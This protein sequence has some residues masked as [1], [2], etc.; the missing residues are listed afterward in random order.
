[1][2]CFTSTLVASLLVTGVVATAL[3]QNNGRLSIEDGVVVKFGANSGMVVHRELETYGVVNFTS[4]GDDTLAGQTQQQ[5]GMPARGDWLGIR[6]TPEVLPLRCKFER[7]NIRYAGQNGA[8]GLDVQSNQVLEGVKISQSDVGLAIS[9]GAV[10]SVREFSLINNR[11][12]LQSSNAIPKIRDSVLSLNLDF[13]ASN[14][15]TSVPGSVP[16]DAKQNYWGAASGPFDAF[17]NPNGTGDK[18]T[19][20]IDYGSYLAHAPLIG[21]TIKP[22]DG[23]YATNIR[24][25]QMLTDCEGA[26]E[27]R[28]S[29]SRLY[30]GSI[31][32]PL[33]SSRA[34]TLSA[35]EGEK[36]IYAQFR[37]A[38]GQTRE[39]F[40]RMHLQNSGALVNITSPPQGSIFTTTDLVTIEAQVE[41]I[42]T[43]IISAV[44]FYINGGL[45]GTDNN[46][47]YLATWNPTGY[48]SGN[49][50]IKAVA[51]TSL[52][53][54][55]FNRINVVL[56][57]PNGPADTA[58][59]VINNIRFNTTPLIEG[60]AITNVGYLTATVSDTGCANN[61][62]VRLTVLLN[63]IPAGSDPS[64][65]GNYRHYLG[66]DKILNGP[67]RLRLAAQDNAGN[68]T[69]V[70]RN[71]ILALGPPAVPVITAP[72]QNQIVRVNPI[73][74][75]GTSDPGT[76]VQLYINNV[77][78]GLPRFASEAGTFENDY[79]LLPSEGTLQLSADATNGQ[80]TSARSANRTIQFIIPPASI[81]VSSPSAGFLVVGP[82]TLGAS[83]IN[84]R[85]GTT[86]E[87]FVN[88][89]SFGVDTTEP[90]SMPFSGVGQSDGVKTVRVLM[91]DTSSNTSV[92]TSAFIYRAAAAIAPEFLP[93]YIGT[94]LSALP[95]VSS[96]NVPIV[97]AGRIR[98]TATPTGQGNSAVTLVLRTQGFERRIN[99]VSEANGDFNYSYTPRTTDEGVFEVFA[100]HPQAK[101]FI[102]PTPTGIA[103]FT[104]QRLSASPARIALQAPRAFGQPFAITVRNSA[105]AIA[106]KVRLIAR[107][108]DQPSNALPFGI[109]FDGGPAQNIAEEGEAVFPVQF[110]S[111]QASPGSGNL[112]I[113][114]LEDSSG[115]LKRSSSRIDF[116]LFPAVPALVV[117]PTSISTG[118]RRNKEGF[119]T[120]T[121]ENKGLV[122]AT[123]VRIQLLPLAPAT[124]VPS[125]ITLVSAPEIA[126]LAVGERRTLQLRF[127]PG[128]AV[129]DAVYSAKLRITGANATGTEQFIAVAVSEAGEGR[130]RF[131]AADIFTQTL[132][133]SNQLIPGLANARID[134][135]LEA[136]PLI[137]AEG[138][139]NALG[140]LILGPL[141][142]GRYTYRAQGPT[143]S[144]SSGRVLL[145]PG[146][147]IDEDVFLDFTT[148]SF[149]WS[150][151]PTTILD[152]YNIILSA[153]YST[154]VPA[155]VVVIEPALV[156][157][158][159]LSV[160][161]YSTGEL[162]VTNF[163]LLR[164]DNVLLD[165]TMS[166]PFFRI[167]IFGDMPN[168]LQP[169]QRI[170]LLYR[171][172]A[173]QDLP[174]RANA[175]ARAQD[176]AAW[177]GSKP[178]ERALA[179]PAAPV[180]AGCNAFQRQIRVDYVYICANGVLRRAT[181]T[182]SFNSTYGPAC[183]NPV[184][185][186]TAIGGCTSPNQGCGAGG[187]YA[188][189]GGGGG[190]VRVGCG[191]DCTQGCACTS[192]CTKPDPDP[193]PPPGP[194]PPVPPK[195]PSCPR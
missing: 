145:R 191:P 110:F 150:V 31:Y 126:T 112:I 53:S 172:T 87:F 129:N 80:G 35:L 49:Y 76:R 167:D 164:A 179:S 19:R 181:T 160:G 34:F 71:L 48:S 60:L 9:R 158:P 104:I 86:V 40:I 171:I 189:G 45:V 26:I 85:G 8:A 54:V 22:A 111:T 148:V 59:P 147:T 120:F 103:N 41:P 90:Y 30:S 153:T 11:I 12:G 142:P 96:G 106:N 178:S 109:S 116:E 159:Q 156:N 93:P 98:E 15:S 46:S 132:D 108:Q 62:A 2:K 84:L 176:L 18:V 69:I 115:T 124:S 166:N 157:I 57:L 56:R 21:C 36:T 133:A 155:P 79:V 190:V 24:S 66:F 194:P 3:A 118:V 72:P 193:E 130:V 144:P 127:A 5:T 37:G 134:L 192:G 92:A 141:P 16:V 182:S 125:W 186:V 139:T 81:V 74:V 121:L 137:R 67:L 43:S 88:N 51:T 143:H 77:P 61:C 73:S 175:T 97:I 149:T 63:D 32:T 152:I 113:S 17:D 100:M 10:P 38:G 91:R 82:T 52:G 195:P 188:G 180:S 168:E 58:P 55:S 122:P 42:D 29:E 173:L 154:V 4:I 117:S 136:N 14:L 20:G 131:R 114:V 94:G 161:E 95:A 170:D 102:N 39:T 101:P 146:A 89:V 105:G 68:T 47:P 23:R 83:V 187:G 165:R 140:E 169:G 184:I 44:Q 64:A 99:L 70:E 25:F 162:T 177:L 119:E 27:L 13:G 28:L 78:A 163:G 1:M 183:I 185:P 6:V 174:N 107:T 7:A 135:T 50:E 123:D 33:S 151:T 128:A 138:I 75:Y 65:L